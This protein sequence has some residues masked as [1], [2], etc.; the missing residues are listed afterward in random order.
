MAEETTSNYDFKKPVYGNSGDD[1]GIGFE[2]TLNNNFELIDAAI[3][4][5]QDENGVNLAEIT[6]GRDG[7]TSLL[8]KNQA[9]DSKF[10]VEHNDDGT[11]VASAESASDF[12]TSGH[13]V[14]YVSATQFTV[15]GDHSLT[16]ET[17]RIVRAVLAASSP[18]SPVLTSSYN[19]GTTLTTVTLKDAILTNPIT[20]IHYGLISRTSLPD[21]WEIP[22]LF[23]KVFVLGDHIAAVFGA[24]LGFPDG[25]LDTFPTS[26]GQG[27][28]EANSLRFQY[29]G[30]NEL[31]KGIDGGTGVDANQDFTN[32][33][34]FDFHKESLSD[35]SVSGDVVTLN[36]GALGANV[37]NGRIII[38][39]NEANIV[40]RDSGT[41]LTV[42][43]GHSLSGTNVAAEIRFHMFN[44]G[45]VKLNQI[46][47]SGTYG[48]D[49]TAGQ[50]YTSNSTPDGGTALGDAFDD[51]VNTYIDWVESDSYP[52]YLKVSLAD[53]K[54]AT[55]AVINVHGGQARGANV[56]FK[57]YGS[58]NDLDWDQLYYETGKTFGSGSGNSNTFQF[59]NTTAYLYY[60]VE[61][62]SSNNPTGFPDWY[63]LEFMED[64]DK[65]VINET[66]P[67]YPQY[68]KLTDSTSWSDENSLAQVETLNSANVWY[69]E[70]FATADYGAGTV[71]KIT[72]GAGNNIRSIVQNN[73][74]TW[75]YNSDATFGS[76]TWTEATADTMIQ[77]IIDA[78]GV[79]ANKMDGTTR[80]ATPDT[81]ALLDISKKRGT[82]VVLYSTVDSNDPQVDQTSI[83]YDSVRAQIILQS[84]DFDPEFSPSEAFLSARMEYVDIDGPGSFYVSRNGGINFDAI[85]M[86]QSGPN[87]VGNIRIL[88]GKIDLT[89]QPVGQALIC[90]YESVQGKDQFLHSWG[91]R[92]KQ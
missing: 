45:V 87:I 83:N 18:K 15:E 65:N 21:I 13:T 10:D 86:A 64:G 50:T 33:V 22:V 90:K 56:S 19:G 1:G 4:A 62:I 25:W 69:F 31:Y 16:Y 75:E 47:S 80:A 68:S 2:G 3:K 91:L 7:E 74:D 41:Q 55:Q 77:A 9:Q 52:L 81:A 36:S 5:R 40:T 92:A 48:P 67:I 12:K 26:N 32:E 59:S 28:D 85:T 27:A 11:H 23:Q 60:K 17:D 63:E 49:I 14:A 6:D 35:V 34:D 89:S 70:I 39:A 54:K 38:G 44:S 73:A 46:S 82:G 76:T 61:W 20:A 84:K 71:L 29:D 24:A 66:I 51:N 79:S 78:M 72:D 42:E 43:S 53:A 8:A 58:N 37:A 57:I 88:T 30:V